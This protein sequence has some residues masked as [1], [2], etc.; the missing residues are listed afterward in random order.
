MK[1]GI[2]RWYDVLAIFVCD[3]P[4]DVPDIVIG[5]ILDEIRDAICDNTRRG[6]T[7]CEQKRNGV[8]RERRVMI[9]L[10]NGFLTLNNLFPVTPF[11]AVA[12]TARVGLAAGQNDQDPNS[13]P[14]SP[15][16]AHIHLLSLAAASRAENE[17]HWLCLQ[18][19]LEDS[20]GMSD[21]RHTT[22]VRIQLSKQINTPRPW[23]A[24]FQ[25]RFP[26]RQNS[27]P[28]LQKYFL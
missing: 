7:R 19:L 17:H 2:M 25:F 6:P 24:R 11:H 4:Y 15:L 8:P 14:H 13:K 3:G 27:V 21:T 22:P 10:L 1:K 28:L 26:D 5:F 12:P 23:T 20:Y 18:T 9:G 16:K